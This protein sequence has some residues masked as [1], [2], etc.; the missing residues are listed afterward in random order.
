MKRLLLV[1]VM[2][3]LPMRVFAQTSQN[4]SAD[5]KDTAWSRSVAAEVAGDLAGAEDILS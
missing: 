2:T 4:E 3:G 5:R 1:L